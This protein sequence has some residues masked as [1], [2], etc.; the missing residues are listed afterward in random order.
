MEYRAN[1]ACSRPESY[2][3]FGIRQLVGHE[4]RAVL[5]AAGRVRLHDAAAAP[6]APPAQYGH[7]AGFFVLLI[8]DPVNTYFEHN[9]EVGVDEIL[10]DDMTKN[11]MSRVLMCI[12]KGDTVGVKKLPPETHE[13]DD[14]DNSFVV[15]VKITMT[16]NHPHF[17]RF[18]VVTWTSALDL[19]ASRH[20]LQPAEDTDRNA[21]CGALAYIHSL[22]LAIIHRDL[23]SRNVLLSSDLVVKRTDFGGRIL[24]G[25][26]AVRGAGFRV[27]G[28]IAVNYQ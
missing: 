20:R 6:T 17:V 14:H 26:S 27:W 11:E 18:V 8:D 24:F 2:D 5:V 21:H 10:K 3:Y 1:S 12:R 23:K 16:L 19:R 7:P 28:F 4:G 15:E 13:N 25:S 22:V 9:F